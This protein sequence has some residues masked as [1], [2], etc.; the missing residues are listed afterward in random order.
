MF[1]SDGMNDRFIPEEV[2]NMATGEKLMSVDSVAFLLDQYL[3][4]M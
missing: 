4:F 3:P 1:T 2:V